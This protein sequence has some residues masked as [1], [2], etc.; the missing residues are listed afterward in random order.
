TLQ[1]I[2]NIINSTTSEFK[3]IPSIDRTIANRYNQKLE[4]VQDWLS[5]T[6]WSQ[7]VIDEQTISTVQSQLL[8]LDIIPNKVSYNDLVYLL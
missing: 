7:G 8:E 1:T 6:E 5:V 2:L 4:D 3:Y